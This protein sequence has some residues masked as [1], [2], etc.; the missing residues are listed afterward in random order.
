[1][2]T[3]RASLLMRVKDRRDSAAWEEFD[4]I[5][6]PLLY[7][8]G[9]AR[10]LQHAEAEDVVQQCMTAVQAHMA[11]F[12][13]DPRKGRFKSWLR[14][15][16]NNRVRNLHRDRREQAADSQDLARDQQREPSPE[17]VF[18]RLWMAE[19][20]RHSLEL[21]RREVDDKTFRAFQLYVID[22]RAVE[23]V[24]RELEVSANRLYKIKWRLTQKLAEHMADLT[25]G[26]E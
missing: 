12:E 6:R 11:G 5:Y 17:E 9:L 14:T 10:G 23:D 7:R 3:T 21:I 4:A 1:M 25:E 8:F 18:D 13:Y 15:L 20:L 24:C 19:H 26:A 22:E 2:H 16:V